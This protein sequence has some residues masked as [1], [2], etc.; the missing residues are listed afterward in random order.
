MA[1]KKK[2]TRTRPRSRVKKTVPP[3]EIPTPVRLADATVDD[4]GFLLA[5]CRE[6]GVSTLKIGEFEC[7]LYPFRP[8]NTVIPSKEVDEE[9]LETLPGGKKVPKRI[10][11]H[12]AK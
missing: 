1:K 12:S 9:D 7:S 10:L 3:A 5:T 11:F 8:Q 6:A 2:T 4:L